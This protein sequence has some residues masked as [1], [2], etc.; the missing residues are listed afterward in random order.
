MLKLFLIY[1]MAL[2][3]RMSPYMSTWLLQKIA[4]FQTLGIGI[5]SSYPRC[6]A[7]SGKRSSKH[8]LGRVL[9]SHK[10]GLTPDKYNSQS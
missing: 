3:K 7:A 1:P 2:H 10:P 5:Q 9:E 8:W 6:S 4:S